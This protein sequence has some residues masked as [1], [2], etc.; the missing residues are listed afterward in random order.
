LDD[1]VR[2]QRLA[3]ISVKRLRL[4]EQRAP[5]TSSLADL[6]LQQRAGSAP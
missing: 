5:P 3:D 6:L 4:D 2:L 1:L